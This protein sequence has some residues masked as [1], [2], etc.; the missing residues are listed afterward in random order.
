MGQ[1]SGMR[2]PSGRRERAWKR[3]NSQGWGTKLEPT[4]ENPPHTALSNLA[5]SPTCPAVL[6][7]TDGLDKS[8]S[9]LPH[10]F[11]GQLHVLSETLFFFHVEVIRVHWR[12]QKAR[13]H[14]WR[15]APCR[16]QALEL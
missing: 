3:R 11:L 5:A 14:R 15:A 6:R 7:I 12:I 16:K 13:M 9:Y 2:R 8:P 1:G 10:M 4:P